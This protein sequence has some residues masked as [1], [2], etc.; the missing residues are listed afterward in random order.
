MH[1][2]GVKKLIDYDDLVEGCLKNDRHC[3]KQLYDIFAP[4][5]LALCE[6]YTKTKHEAEDVMIDGFVSIFSHLNDFE[7]K[8]SLHTWIYK[9]M[10]NAALQYL[11]HNTKFKLYHDI[12]ENVEMEDENNIFNT[13]KTAQEIMEMLRNMPEDLKL[14]FNLRVFEEYKFKEI[15]EELQIPENTARVY[16]FRA[17]EWVSQQITDCKQ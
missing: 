2:R 13:D 1:L 4:E 12:R 17:K 8:S 15:S 14:V 11:R 9:I 3:Q 5:M 16:F 10:V 6:R 7:K